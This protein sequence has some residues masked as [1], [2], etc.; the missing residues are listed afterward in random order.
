MTNKY[1]SSP[2]IEAIFNFI[3]PTFVVYVSSKYLYTCTT[4]GSLQ[5]WLAFFVLVFSM[6]RCI[7]PTFLDSFAVFIRSIKSLFLDSDKGIFELL[8]GSKYLLTMLTIIIIALITASIAAP[9]VCKK[10]VEFLENNARTKIQA[11]K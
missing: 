3:I 9:Q 2:L 4:K 10:T 5:T 1:L 8:A 7:P 11:K 6:S